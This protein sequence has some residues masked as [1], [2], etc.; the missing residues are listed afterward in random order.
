MFK[1]AKQVFEKAAFSQSTS[2]RGEAARGKLEMIFEV[3]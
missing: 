2:R 3:L 1:R